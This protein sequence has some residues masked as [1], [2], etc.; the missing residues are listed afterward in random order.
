MNS[1]IQAPATKAPATTPGIDGMA[2][3]PSFV[4]VEQRP[5]NLLDLVIYDRIQIIGGILG[6]FLLAKYGPKGGKVVTGLY[7]L[8]GFLVGCA[9]TDYAIHKGR[10]ESFAGVAPA[11]GFVSGIGIFSA[12]AAANHFF[13]K[14]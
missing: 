13:G 12:T 8:S 6:A 11:L 4:I 5:K 7:G 3:Q 1:V 10:Y 2:K 9:L 14:K